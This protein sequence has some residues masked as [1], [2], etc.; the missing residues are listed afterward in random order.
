MTKAKNV[1]NFEP[2]KGFKAVALMLVFNV[3]LKFD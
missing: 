1:I 2:K 3:P